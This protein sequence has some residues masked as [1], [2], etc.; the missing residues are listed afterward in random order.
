MHSEGRYLLRSNLVADD[1]SRLWS[2]YM[3]LTQIEQ[4]FKELKHELNIRPIY[5]QLDHRIKA[6]IFVGFM[7]YCLSVT[8]KRILKAKASGYTAKE[9]LEQLAVIQMVDV[10]VPTVSGP[11]RATSIHQARQAPRGG[12]PGVG[13]EASQSADGLHA[14]PR[15][16]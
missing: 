5:R 10:A 16:G 11:D 2:L 13:N 3:M 4:A 6:H 15:R 14:G 7:A 8:L 12:P 9:V 1:P